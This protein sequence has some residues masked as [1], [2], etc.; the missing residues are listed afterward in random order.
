MVERKLSTNQQCAVASEKPV[1][2]GHDS[3]YRV[4][5]GKLQQPYSSLFA[6]YLRSVQLSNL[7]E[8]GV[9]SERTEQMGMLLGRKHP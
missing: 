7:Q 8:A 9:A 1:A 6:P 3:K 4:K 2:L 5:G